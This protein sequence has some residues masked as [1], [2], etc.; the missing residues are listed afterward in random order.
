[1]KKMSFTNKDGTPTYGVVFPE[2]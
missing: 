2:M 1:M